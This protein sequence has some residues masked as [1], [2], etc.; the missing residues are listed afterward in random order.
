[1][2]ADERCDACG[3]A[4]AYG[5]GEMHV[6]KSPDGGL[7]WPVALVHRT[8]PDPMERPS[9]TDDPTWHLMPSGDCVRCGHGLSLHGGYPRIDHGACLVCLSQKDDSPPSAN[10]V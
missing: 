9:V 5:E 8:C 6:L 7:T 3:Q 4:V 10:S 1:M 2:S